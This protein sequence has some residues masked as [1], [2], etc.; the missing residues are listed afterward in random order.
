M[1]GSKMNLLLDTDDLILCECGCK[2]IN[3]T[4]LVD[5]IYIYCA[6][7]NCTRHILTAEWG[8]VTRYWNE[9]YGKETKN[10]IRE[11]V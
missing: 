5:I 11:N 2:T 6:N 8:G 1:N 10:G 9:T 4:R 3:I 7:P